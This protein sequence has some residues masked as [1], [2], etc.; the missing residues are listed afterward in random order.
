MNSFEKSLPMVL[1]RTLD[2][3]MPPYRELFARHDLTE[4]QWRILRVLWSETKVTS[5]T[6]AEM[7]L[8]PSPSLVGILDRLEK[9]QL[10][11]RI[12]S[13]KDRRVV[14]VIATPL[15]RALE[16]EVSP[17]V[18]DINDRL[19]SAISHEEWAAMLAALEKISAVMQTTAQLPSVKKVT[20]D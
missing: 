1:N 16:T 17:S 12:R 11:A 9:K 13:D 3:V 18:A 8:I 2:A 4:Q 20:Q 10:V 15:G 14:H 6:L 5:A 7:T 19:T